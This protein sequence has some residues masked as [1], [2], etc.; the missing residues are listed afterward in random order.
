L[1][2]SCR[3][4]RGAV[5]DSMLIGVPDYASTGIPGIEVRFSRDLDDGSVWFA[6]WRGGRLERLPIPRVGDAVRLP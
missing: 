4:T 6:V 1:M 2:M 5:L 3:G